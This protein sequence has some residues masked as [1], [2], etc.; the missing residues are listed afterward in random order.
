[1]PDKWMFKH[2]ASIQMKSAPIHVCLRL[3]SASYT[4]CDAHTSCMDTCT[5]SQRW[6]STRTQEQQ[7]QPQPQKFGAFSVMQVHLCTFVLCVFCFFLRL[8]HDIGIIDGKASKSMSVHSEFLIKCT[9][10]CFRTLFFSEF[11][12]YSVQAVAISGKRCEFCII[13]NQ[14]IIW[15]FAISLYNCALC[16]DRRKSG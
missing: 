4:E 6:I 5:H 13:L 9:P 3:F 2:F 11:V 14:N 16:F 10:I 15:T 8:F 7:Q 12:T 1:M